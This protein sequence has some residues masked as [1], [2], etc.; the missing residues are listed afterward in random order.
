MM[1][2]IERGRTRSHF[3]EGWAWRR[4]WSCRKTDNGM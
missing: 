2:E 3:L 1:L 4:L